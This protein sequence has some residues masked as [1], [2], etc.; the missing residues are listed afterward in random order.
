ML[1]IAPYGL[2]RFSF[3]I[4]VESAV[5]A[6][7]SR[8]ET[9]AAG[10]HQNDLGLNGYYTWA[11]LGYDAPLTA[12]ERKS[13]PP[14]LAGARTVADLMATEDGAAWWKANGTGRRMVFDLSPGS[15]SRQALQHYLERKQVKL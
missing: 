8:I 2:G 4:Q 7:Y 5:Q 15:R 6:G 11:R 9:Y 13:L 14:E 3:A 10:S 1:R 12:A